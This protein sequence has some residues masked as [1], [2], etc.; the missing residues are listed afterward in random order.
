MYSRLSALVKRDIIYLDKML[1][2]AFTEVTKLLSKYHWHVW[3]H[4]NVVQ[5]TL[6][7]EQIQTI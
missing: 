3:L 2:N 5:Y 4:T 1:F 7:K 6:L